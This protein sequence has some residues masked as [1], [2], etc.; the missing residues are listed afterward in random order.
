M[1][2]FF[3][4]LFLS[5][6]CTIATAQTTLGPGDIAFTLINM[7]GTNE[8]ALAFVLLKDVGANTK[9]VITDDELSGTLS[10]VIILSSV[11]CMKLQHHKFKWCRLSRCSRFFG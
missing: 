5:L 9:I 2:H 6:A 3:N 11:I 7:D 1:K 8:D 10:T 4:L